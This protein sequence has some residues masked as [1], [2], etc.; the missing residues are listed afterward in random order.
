MPKVTLR[1]LRGSERKDFK[2]C[3]Q[4]WWWGWREGLKPQGPPNDKLWFGEGVHVALALWYPPGRKRG[5][6][7][8]ITWRKFAQDDIRFI[9][10]NFP[11][12]PDL[13]VYEDAVEFGEELLEGYLKEYG[14]DDSWDIIAP[15]Q[16]FQ[17]VI[18]DRDGK[19][20]VQLDGT[21]D[22]V[23][24]D[25]ADRGKPKLLETKTAKQIQ[26]AH[27]ELDSQGGTYYTVADRVL[28]QQG[29][30]NP[31]EHI[32]EITYNFLKKIKADDRP[33]NEFGQALNK[34]GSVSKIQ[35]SPRFL[36]EP[37]TRTRVE[38]GRQIE[39]IAAE[40]EA[41][42]MFRTGELDLY[43]NDT[44]DCHWDCEF[45]EMCMLDESNPDEVG[46]FKHAVY[47]VEDP[48][49]AHRKSAAA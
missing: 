16:S 8:R 10:T 9:R 30:I 13:T 14:Q 47:R 12:T 28:R 6:D 4:R 40:F 49:A 26:T 25:L 29:L 46:E 18:P 20:L 15:E 3:P 45:Y 34:D 44:R 7:P 23:Y 21:F 2:R 33:T 22:G 42:E 11:A 17:I 31:T 19:P 38:A 48:Y 37:V 41:M 36:R 32:V 5:K 39:R 35:P 1:H 24:R 43:K 27:L